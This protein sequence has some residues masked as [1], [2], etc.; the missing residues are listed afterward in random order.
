MKLFVFIRWLLTLALI[1]GAYRET[2]PFTAVSL[3][4]IF[5]S[6]ELITLV[7]EGRKRL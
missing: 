1:Y 2:G 4:L 3:F 5:V 7:L 6:I